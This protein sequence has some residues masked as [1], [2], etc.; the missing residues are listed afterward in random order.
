MTAVIRDKRSSEE[1]E[2]RRDV[3]TTLHNENLFQERTIRSWIIALA[4]FGGV[5]IGVAATMI[6]G[7]NQPIID[8]GGTLSSLA[9]P[10]HDTAEAE[11]SVQRGERG[12][13]QEA[14][15]NT[16][17]HQWL[18]NQRALVRLQTD[19]RWQEESQREHLTRAM[20]DTS[21]AIQRHRARVRELE[22]TACEL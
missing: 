18:M 17:R 22:G 12:E 1:S 6:V 20:R 3:M 13:T 19:P 9:I 5:L 4:L 14:E 15:L 11:A 7:N 8:P 2:V 21:L 16:A 10:M